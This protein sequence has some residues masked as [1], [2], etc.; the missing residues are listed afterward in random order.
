MKIL[1]TVRDLN[2]KKKLGGIG[3]YYSLL[4]N[5]W[6]NSVDYFYIGK[7][8]RDSKRV[9]FRLFIDYKNLFSCVNNYDIIVLNPSMST[10]SLLRDSISILICNL[11]RRKKIVY[12]RGWHE[13][14]VNKIDNNKIIY[15][16]FKWIYNKSDAF[17]VLSDNFKKKLREWGFQQKIFIE[18]TVVD[19]KIINGAIANATRD[20]N[21]NSINLLFLAR[22]ERTKGIYEVID[23]YERLK[24]IYPEIKLTIAGDGSEMDSIKSIAEKRK[25]R[26]IEFTGY[27]TGEVKARTLA[28][29]DI[30]IF[31]TFHGEGMPNSVLEAMAFGLP[32][33]TR[34]VGGLRDFFEDGKMGFITESKDPEVFAQLTE[35]LILD[36]DLR[37]Q[38]GEY[39]AQFA[40]KHFLASVVAKR[41]ERIY[42]DVLN[43]EVVERSWMDTIEENPKS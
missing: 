28:K 38:M 25:I 30:Y 22:V 26:D 40:R 41:L 16:L 31:P 17:I 9:I 20:K 35:K 29:S 3:N 36:P 37:R 7:R 14:M 33:I 8:Y 6:S 19:N 1:L 12:F 5:Y 32:V 23:V 43:G 10:T 21:N 11:Y 42:E 39:N 13:Y 2:S 4:R 34:P 24:Q 27:V 15:A 18:T